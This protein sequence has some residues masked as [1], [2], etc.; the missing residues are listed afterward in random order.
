MAQG[1]AWRE[2]VTATADSY[3]WDAKALIQQYLSNLAL[4]AS[5][6]TN[7]GSGIFNGD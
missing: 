2:E 5:A 3:N 4:F 6:M 1:Q 7:Q